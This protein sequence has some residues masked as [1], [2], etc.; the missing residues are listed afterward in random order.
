MPDFCVLLLSAVVLA[1]VGC[2]TTHGQSTS[3]YWDDNSITTAVKTRLASDQMGSVT[4]IEVETIHGIV[5]LNGVVDS[6]AEKG[7]V[8]R[9]AGS[10]E[11]VNRVV[12]YLQVRR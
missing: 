9:A 4:R 8:E 3:S 5:H 1:S 7:R 2:E 10:V 6:P 11:G 12:S